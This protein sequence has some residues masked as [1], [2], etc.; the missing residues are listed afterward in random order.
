MKKKPLISALAMLLAVML[1]SLSCGICSVTLCFF[2]VSL[3]DT[4][5]VICSSLSL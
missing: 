5:G 1:L 4:V 2:K 3:V